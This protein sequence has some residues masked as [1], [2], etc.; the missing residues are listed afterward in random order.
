MSRAKPFGASNA[1]AI[2]STVLGL[3]SYFILMGLMFMPMLAGF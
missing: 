1:R 2:I 3:I